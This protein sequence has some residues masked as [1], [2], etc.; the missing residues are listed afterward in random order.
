MLRLQGLQGAF[1]GGGEPL[2]R[3]ALIVLLI[4]LFCGS[5]GPYRCL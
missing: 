2:M 4:S 3:F 1:L 5:D